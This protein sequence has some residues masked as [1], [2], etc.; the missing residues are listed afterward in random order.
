M[1]CVSDLLRS[2]Y[3]LVAKN[4]LC[5]LLNTLMVARTSFDGDLEQFLIFIVV[6]QR[7]AEDV[8]T[9]K[10]KLE[11]VLSG[12]VETYPSL[13]TNVRSIADSTGIPRETVRRK[14]AQLIARGW[15]ERVEDGLAITPSASRALTPV[16]EQILESAAHAH[17]VV[18]R[19]LREAA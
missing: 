3:A 5:P 16:R 19:L 18:A 14:I 6:A 4:L 12:E 2:Q 8:R 17:E 10:L 11:D 15:V 13:R 1:S 7:T 9:Q